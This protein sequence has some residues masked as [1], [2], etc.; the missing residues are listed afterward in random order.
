MCRG[1]ERELNTQA[2]SAF[3]PRS[4]AGL[5]APGSADGVHTDVPSKILIR[6]SLYLSALTAGH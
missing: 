1:A 6:G 3:T 4:E 2:N 5:P